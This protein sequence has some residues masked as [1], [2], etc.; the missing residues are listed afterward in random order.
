ML[1]NEISRPHVSCMY[2]ARMTAFCMCICYV[3]FTVSLHQLV[4][5]TCTCICIR[6]YTYT[7]AS[8]ISNG[9]TTIIIVS[10]YASQ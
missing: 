2:I 10:P 4:N 6:A 3:R 8:V 9:I 5:F 1:L 7:E